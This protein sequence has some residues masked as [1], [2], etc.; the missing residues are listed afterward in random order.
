VD[1]HGNFGS[2]DGDS[3]AA[4]R[5]TEARMQPLA[6]QMLRDI[7]KDTVR[8]EIIHELKDYTDTMIREDLHYTSVS[9]TTLVNPKGERYRYVLLPTWIV[10]YKDHAGKLWHYAMNG[11]TG[12]L[13]GKLPVDKGKVAALGAAIG[14]SLMILTLIA[15][16]LFA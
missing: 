6:L 1:G 2:I 7:D 10:T 16:W 3:A 5:Y 12:A 14:G 15:G 8:P 4:M 9:G 11:Q 13:C